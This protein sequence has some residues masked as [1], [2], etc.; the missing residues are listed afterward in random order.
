MQVLGLQTQE[1]QLT[2]YIILPKERNGLNQLEKQRIQYGK[3]LQQLL[4][5]VDGRKETLKVQLP[6]FQ[7]V[8]KMDTKQILRKLGVENAFDG[9]D[10]D[11]SAINEEVAEETL[12]YGRRQ[13]GGLEDV[14]A[15]KAAEKQQQ[16]HLN[17]L[18]Q[19]ATIQVFFL[20]NQKIKVHCFRFLD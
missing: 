18:I 6:V 19:L 9:D 2:I 3:Q 15:K 12:H 10:A 7:I 20:L 16:L 4:D 8:H 13:T 17:K 14:D 11:F 5:A 1:K